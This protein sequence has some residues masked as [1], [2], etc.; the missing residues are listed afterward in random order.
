VQD[1]EVVKALLSSSDALQVASAT[2]ALRRKSHNIASCVLVAA[3]ALAE[4]VSSA[5][6]PLR[7]VKIRVKKIEW[8]SVKNPMWGCGPVED[9]AKE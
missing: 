3:K 8:M 7:A 1:S 5:A 9:L 6:I 4:A 2:S